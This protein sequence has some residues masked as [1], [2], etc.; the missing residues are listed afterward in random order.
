M[1]MPKKVKFRKQHRGRV[2]GTASQKTKLDFGSF[3]LKALSNS[4]V[5]SR[6]IEAA[7]RAITRHLKRGGKLWIRIFPDKAVTAKGD[8]PMGTGKGTV[9]H[10]VA[11]VKKGTMLFELDGVTKEIAVEAFR[12][13]AHKLP[14]ET[15]F[16]SKE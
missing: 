15:K 5:T 10:Y 12:L 13:A 1:F 6:Q 16:L 8:V 3:G 4:W 11:P 7:R 9:E 2:N 14:V